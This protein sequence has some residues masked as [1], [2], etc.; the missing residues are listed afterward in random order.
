MAFDPKC[1]ELAEYFLPTDPVLDRLR[2]ELAQSI[3]DA[4]ET[5]LHIERDHLADDVA[6]RDRPH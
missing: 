2:T 1:Y 3:Q 4:V 6:A 5:F